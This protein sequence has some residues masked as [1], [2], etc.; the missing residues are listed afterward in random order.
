MPKWMLKRR[1]SAQRPRAPE[2]ARADE[3]GTAS[4]WEARGLR[5]FGTRRS[6]HR[7]AGS[8]NAVAGMSQR[9]G[10]TRT[11]AEPSDLMNDQGAL[12]TR[13]KA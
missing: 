10:S 6:G 11:H 8:W 12:S 1:A 4:P 7:S 3:G 13:N 2:T 5:T 9:S